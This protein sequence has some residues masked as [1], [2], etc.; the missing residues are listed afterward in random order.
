MEPDFLIKFCDKC[1]SDYKTYLIKYVF[2]DLAAFKI[3]NEYYYGI[4]DNEISFKNLVKEVCDEFTT[5]FDFTS[6]MPEIERLLRMKYHLI[7]T[8]KEP[9][10]KIREE[11]IYDGRYNY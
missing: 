9:H 1:F 10:I 6:S 2:P 8:K 4:I 11:N 5:M 3:S 7:I